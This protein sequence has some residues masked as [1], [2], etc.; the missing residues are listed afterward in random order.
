[1]STLLSN[2]FKKELPFESKEEQQRTFEELNKKVSSAPILKFP[3]F[4]KLF[5]VH[6]DA[7]DFAIDGVFIQD[8]HPIA[9]ENTQRVAKIIVT[10]YFF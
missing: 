2:I 8:G 1:M 9:G 5:K 4:T 10:L 6:I 3:D 7:S